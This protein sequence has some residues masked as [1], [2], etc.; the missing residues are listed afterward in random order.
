[1]K[2]TIG[3]KLYMNLFVIIIIL[4]LLFIFLKSKITA[5]NECFAQYSSMITEV[6][7]GKDLQLNVANVWQF[8]TDASLV[9][10]ESV[11][12]KEAVAAREKALNDIKELLKFGAGNDEYNNRLENINSQLAQVFIVGRKMFA[13]YS[14]DWARGNIVMD[15]FDKIS[16]SLIESVN[17]LIDDIAARDIKMNEK[18]KS[19][20]TGLA[21]AVALAV[22]LI[23]FIMIVF[24]V[25]ISNNIGRI[26]KS[27]TLEIQKITQKISDGDLK[28]RCDTE[29]INFEFRGIV[30]GINNTLNAVIDPLNVAAKCVARIS[31]GDI[32]SRITD[33]YNGD[34]NEIKNNL[35]HCIEAVNSLVAEADLL[36]KAAV[37]G[38]LATRADASKHQG[39]FR[40][41]MQ[42]V[43]ETLDALIRP[44]NVAANYIER[45][46]KVDI[47]PAITENYNGDFNTI[48][49]NLNQCVGSL[50]L[51]MKDM[52]TLSDK[53]LNGDL[54]YRI[55]EAKHDK[56]FIKI[57]TGV[58]GVLDSVIEPIKEAS[59][60][61]LEMSKGNLDI[62][63]AGNYKGDHATLKN[64]I[65]ETVNS[66][67]EILSHVSVAAEQVNAGAG[68]VSDASQSL[69]QTATESA[70]SLEEIGASMHEISSQAG[71]NSGNATRASAI[72]SD[73]KKSA[74]DGNGKMRDMQKAMTDINESAGNVARII[75]AIDEIAFQTNLL[76]L[77][78]A[79]E[80]ARA[81]KH[82]K[83]FTVV[84]GEVRNLAQRSAK[85]AKE[86]AELIDSSI[87]KAE[88]GSKIAVDTAGSLGKIVA[89][90]AEVTDLIGEIAAASK[91]QERGVRHVNTGIA[92]V[93]IVT[94]QNTATAEEAAAASEELSAQAAEL[95]VML[96][97]F[98]LKKASDTVNV[99]ISS[100]TGKAQ[101]YKE[102]GQ[103][104]GAG[105]SNLKPFQKQIAGNPKSG[106]G[107]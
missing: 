88:A 22:I 6:K 80:A 45:I 41:I 12:N 2:L 15:E 57:V 64:A 106:I 95:K 105:R 107:G 17:F 37:E 82:G 7:L 74:D 96:E 89:G 26:I 30:E 3:K 55:N 61:L 93:D 87:K 90:V 40:K 20:L 83:G 23:S 103:N 67:N 49:T 99:N 59:G 65:N 51:L 56:G 58:N 5:L 27:L 68:Q 10:D 71:R 101:A 24:N 4:S 102:S 52:E 92:Q 16:G 47:P 48:K 32:P 11:I 78:A 19:L 94:Q 104:G 77:N 84:A 39:D 85:A 62:E 79:V 33:K 29:K 14:K 86:T 34:F 35:N 21:S 54:S 8:F 69:S 100:V 73:V 31:K 53:A 70:S 1:M 81:G 97:R 25:F 63:I 9:K 66:M 72:A 44:L 18:L 98:R 75:K 46:S 28:A 91:E 76:A 36:A 60:C 13:A 50:A 43:N 38:N 42:G